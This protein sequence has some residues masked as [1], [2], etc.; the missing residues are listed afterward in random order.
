M[1]VQLAAEQVGEVDSPAA[2]DVWSLVAAVGNQIFVLAPRVGQIIGE[3][4][5]SEGAGWSI[6]S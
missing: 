2:L 4:S 1:R 3:E 6:S 5:M